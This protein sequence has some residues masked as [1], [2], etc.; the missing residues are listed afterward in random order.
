MLGTFQVQHV[1]SS[2][3]DQLPALL[4]RHDKHHGHHPQGDVYDDDDTLP[5]QARRQKKWCTKGHPILND[6]IVS[7][8]KVDKG[9]L[10]FFVA[11]L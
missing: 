11:R 6:D 10:G 3:L 2:L 4:S 1:P 8:W 7:S 5:V 9:H